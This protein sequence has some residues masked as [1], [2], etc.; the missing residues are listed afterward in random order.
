MAYIMNKMPKIRKWF[1]NDFIKR[2]WDE[3]NRLV[4]SLYEEE[5]FD[6]ED[7]SINADD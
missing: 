6:T 1:Y 3:I 4:Y 2:D 7:F 5:H